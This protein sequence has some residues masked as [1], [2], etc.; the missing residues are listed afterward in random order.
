[1]CAS[2]NNTILYEAAAVFHRPPHILPPE[3]GTFVQYVADNADIN[4]NTLD[5]H[6]TL[7]IMGI[8]QVVTPKSL[9]LL[10]EAIQRIKE[11]PSATDFAAIA[12]MPL[13]IY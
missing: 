6:N 12:H 1:M 3:T 10:E 5:G 4:V 8:I 9:V 2:Y 7:H 11:A 13:Q